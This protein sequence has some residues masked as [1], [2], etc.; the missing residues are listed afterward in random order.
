[1]KYAIEAASRLVRLT[2]VG[3]PSRAE[4][5]SAHV[6][7]FRHPLYGPGFDFLVD[8]QRA[9]TPTALELHDFAAFLREHRKDVEGA[10]VALVVA[11]RRAGGMPDLAQSLFATIPLTL[12]VFTSLE[13]AM[14][15]LM[16]G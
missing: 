6:A 10:R 13:D 3:E 2:A 5:R 9:A 12:E 16:G 1:V 11:E 7:I 15:W 4:V 14:T 8:W